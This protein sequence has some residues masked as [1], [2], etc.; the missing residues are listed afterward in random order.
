[1]FSWLGFVGMREEVREKEN[2]NQT[3]KLVLD[4]VDLL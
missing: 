1:M 4:S 3:P 2:Q